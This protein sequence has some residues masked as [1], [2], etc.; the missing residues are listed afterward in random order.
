[1]DN[2]N[3]SKKSFTN[4]VTPIKVKSGI[5]RKGLRVIMTILVIAIIYIISADSD[6]SM[7]VKS[8]SLLS[9]K[10]TAQN[11]IDKNEE[12]SEHSIEKLHE[13]TELQQPENLNIKSPLQINKLLGKQN[14]KFAYIT[15][16]H[17][18][19]NTFRWATLI[20]SSSFVLFANVSASLAFFS[21]SSLVLFANASVVFH[22]YHRPQTTDSRVHTL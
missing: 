3:K 16:V 13:K 1:M 17:G 5:L 6:V 8:S 21:A 11:D 10:K 18:I 9:E 12:H 19:D 14:S 22:T 2:S 20:V 4:D 7:K 15:L